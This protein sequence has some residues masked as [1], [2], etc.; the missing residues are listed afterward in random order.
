MLGV[1]ACAD[2]DAYDSDRDAQILDAS[3]DASRDA[4]VDDSRTA[5][6]TDANVDANMGATGRDGSADAQPDARGNPCDISDFI[7][8]PQPCSADQDCAIVGSCSAASAST[9][10]T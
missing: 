1:I 6:H 8:T 9:P 3:L 7:A 5:A 2:D 4:S 10:S